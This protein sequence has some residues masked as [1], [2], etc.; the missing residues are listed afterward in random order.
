MRAVWPAAERRGALRFRAGLRKRR[1]TQKAC[2]TVGNFC[3]LDFETWNARV[4][5][6]LVNHE[7]L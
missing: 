7:S 3:R 4:S 5:V 1:V 6:E 2:W